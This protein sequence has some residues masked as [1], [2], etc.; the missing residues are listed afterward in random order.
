MKQISI[1]TV[2]VPKELKEK[3]KTIDMNWSEY[4]RTA[5]LRRIEEESMKK[6]SVRLDEIRA[7][8]KPVPTE[9][10]LRWIREDR[11]R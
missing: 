9:E 5:I 2:K 10:L 3:M 7:Q 8:A 6:A 11:S 1:I 4:I